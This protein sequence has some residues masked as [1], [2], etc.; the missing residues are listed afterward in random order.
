MKRTISLLCFFAL[1]ITIGAPPVV[2]KSND[3]QPQPDSKDNETADDVLNKLEYGRYLKEVVEILESD[4]E[5]KKK[6]EN[7]SLDDIK[8][9]NIAEH[10]SLVQHHIRTQLDEA[11]QREMTRLKDLVGQRVRNLNERQRIALA[12]ADPNGKMLKEFLPQHID[13]KNSETFGQLDLERLIRHA[14]KD[15]DELDRKREQ[16]FKE[17]EMQK[18]YQRRQKL[19]KL[20]IEERKRLEKLH[21]EALE[22]KKKHPKV[23][24]PG[25]VDQMEE[26]WEKV[27]NLDADQFAPKSFFQLHD[28]NSDGFLD[29]GELEAIML[30][31]A[32]KIHDETPE[33]DPVEKQEEMDRMREH[34]MKEFDKN[35]DRMLSL[36]EFMLGLN[37]TNAKNEQGWQSIEDNAVFS[38]QEF[39]DFSEKLAPV[40]TSIPPHQ[41]PS[42]ASIQQAQVQPEAAA[43]RPPLPAVQVPPQA[44]PPQQQQAHIP[45]APNNS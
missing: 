42:P 43:Q 38:N 29:Q 36:D 27:D 18:E 11:K 44:Q 4:P 39:Q 26:V 12:R 13:H 45:R 5:F 15:L 33:A 16:Q 21:E 31:E 23:N 35:N 3:D 10:L 28:I 9:G 37:G 22:K 32:E 17:Y 40:S 1:I 24:H 25:S 30:K 20:S 8:S 6:I 34:V 2:E 14:S 41:T 7:A 19:S